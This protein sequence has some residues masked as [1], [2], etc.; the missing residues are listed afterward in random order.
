MKTTKIRRHWWPWH[1]R[2]WTRI[3]F[4]IPSSRT[5]RE[6]AEVET[7]HDLQK[8]PQQLLCDVHEEVL[9]VLPFY[10]KL[11]N[12]TPLTDADKLVCFSALLNSQKRIAS[13]NTQTSF[14]ARRIA[15]LSVWIAVLSVC[16]ALYA[17]LSR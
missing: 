15:R 1:I 11:R 17:M 3:D 9:E 10:D 2:N 14:N 8:S 5:K 12:G 7:D 16:I 4:D 6:L 13:L